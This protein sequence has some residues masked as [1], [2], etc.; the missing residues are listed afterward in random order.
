VTPVCGNGIVET[1]EQCDD[2]NRIAANDSCMANCQRIP[3]LLYPTIALRS[4]TLE[5]LA[6]AEDGFLYQKSLNRQNQVWTR[7]TRPSVGTSHRI[8]SYIDAY[9]LDGNRVDVFGQDSVSAHII[10][11]T[12]TDG[13]WIFGWEEEPPATIG[14]V[15]QNGT[16]TP[17]TPT[18]S[19]NQ[20]GTAV[21]SYPIPSLGPLLLLVFAPDGAQHSVWDSSWINNWNPWN[22]I[23]PDAINS[24][25]DV[26]TF[27]FPSN[28]EQD[29][30]VTALGLDLQ[31]HAI[32][33]TAGGLWQQWL[34]LPPLANGFGFGSCVVAAPI[35]GRVD[36]FAPASDNGSHP[37]TIRH[38]ST[39]A[40]LSGFSA[41][42]SW[43]GDANSEPDCVLDGSTVHLVYGS[44]VGGMTYM[45]RTLGSA[46]PAQIQD[47]GGP[48]GP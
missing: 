21:V 13:S 6:I 33:S 25:P 40:S 7:W 22:R 27:F 47:L 19:T 23:A 14:G 34:Q 9:S 37:F 15:D 29:F 41:W 48:T 11:A 35:F 32:A 18:F 43:G 12:A 24:S 4:T 3:K 31:V 8:A 26:A 39:D 10:Q 20:F 46:T 44:A 36:L 45:S 38:N 5:F 16:P 17:N 28:N 1:G 30:V 2:G 42:E